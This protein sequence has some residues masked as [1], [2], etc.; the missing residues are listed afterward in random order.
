MLLTGKEAWL[1][2][3]GE[4]D[5]NGCRGDGTFFLDRGVRLADI[6]DGTSDTV[7]AGEPVGEF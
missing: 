3:N 1:E 7:V 4:P 2:S 6:L 5:Y